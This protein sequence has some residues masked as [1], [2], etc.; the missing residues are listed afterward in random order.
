MV[1]TQQLVDS[2]VQCMWS[3]LLAQRL[4]CSVSRLWLLAS[5]LTLT[6]TKQSLGLVN[7]ATTSLAFAR[8]CG[9]R[10]PV[11]WLM[12]SPELRRHTNASLRKRIF[13]S[14][15]PFECVAVT[16]TKDVG[17]LAIAEIALSRLSAGEAESLGQAERSHLQLEGCSGVGMAA[18]TAAFHPFRYFGR[19]QTERSPRHRIN[20]RTTP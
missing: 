14:V 18:F 16:E 2:L 10:T 9:R 4:L 8:H 7:A 20:C 6:A 17:S 13:C 12:L 3:A 11:Q 5:E 1:I 15:S 19:L